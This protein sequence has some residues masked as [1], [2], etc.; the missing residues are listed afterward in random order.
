MASFRTAYDQREVPLNLAVVGDCKVGDFVKVTP[1][2]DTVN[3]YMQKATIANATHIVAQ[4]DMTLNA[5]GKEFVEFIEYRYDDTVKASQ[6]AVPMAASKATDV[7]KHVAL[8]QI[9]DKN[10][11]IPAPDGGD[12]A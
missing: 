9:I 4:S 3:A 1:A 8:Y 11:V 6:A 7:I 2:T 5:V 10:D 12:H